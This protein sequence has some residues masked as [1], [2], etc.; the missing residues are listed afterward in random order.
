MVTVHID[1][2][3]LFS[4]PGVLRK[5]DVIRYGPLHLWCYYHYKNVEQI[6]GG[7]LHQGWDRQ[8]LLAGN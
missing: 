7:L 4:G 8:P 3:G 6:R 2:V 1:P 5:A